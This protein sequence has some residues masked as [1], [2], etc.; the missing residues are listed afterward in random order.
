MGDVIFT[1][2]ICAY[3]GFADDGGIDVV[4]RIDS[5]GLKDESC[6]Y[7]STLNQIV[8]ANMLIKIV[9][10]VQTLVHDANVA[11]EIFIS[12]TEN[13]PRFGEELSTIS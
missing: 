3:A 1:F 10:T 9:D 11:K 4:S 8:N 12:T 5:D 2:A 6:A 13:F 7:A